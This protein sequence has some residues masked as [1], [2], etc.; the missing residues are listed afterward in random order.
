[1]SSKENYKCTRNLETNKII[2][3]IYKSQLCYKKF[4]YLDGKMEFCFTTSA[5]TFPCFPT[6]RLVVTWQRCV[7]KRADFILSLKNLV[8]ESLLVCNQLRK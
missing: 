3:L 7:Y 1:M 4:S 2:F 5:S 6:D 8:I